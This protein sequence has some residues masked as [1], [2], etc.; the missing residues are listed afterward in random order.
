MSGSCTLSKCNTGFQNVNGACTSMDITSDVNNCG[1]VGKVCVFP[2]G[3]GT[4]SAGSCTYTS[5][6]APYALKSGSCTAVD[7]NTDVKNCGSIGNVC[8]VS[9]NN[10]GAGQCVNGGCRTTCNAGF[11]FD[12]DL[13]YC[14]DVTSDVNN[15]WAS[16]FDSIYRTTTDP[17]LSSY[18]GRC[19]GV[20][21][22]NGAMATK[23][24]YSKCYAT[25][26]KSGYYLQGGVCNGIDTTSDS[27]SLS[28]SPF[29]PAPS[30]S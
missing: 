11:D 30:S 18:S 17:S 10:G 14:R 29:S 2:L 16:F 26:C 1:A 3:Q 8:P 21:S 9:Y 15:W 20:C 12:T 24:V 13:N 5:C 6:N 28:C 23:C 27:S 19:G 7:T 4:C 22:L 25:S